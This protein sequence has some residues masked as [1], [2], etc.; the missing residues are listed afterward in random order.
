[1]LQRME[2]TTHAKNG[3]GMIFAPMVFQPGW[4]LEH[5]EPPLVQD[6]PNR[7]ADIIRADRVNQ[8]LGVRTCENSSLLA[9][10][11]TLNDP[12]TAALIQVKLSFVDSWTGC[13]VRVVTPDLSLWNI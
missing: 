4:I 6:T 7:A 2:C 3:E 1:M 5:W 11:M 13:A 9:D 8:S 10:D 12:V